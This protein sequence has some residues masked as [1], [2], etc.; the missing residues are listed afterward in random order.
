MLVQDDLQ[1]DLAG[2]DR[3]AVPSGFGRGRQLVDG[4]PGGFTKISIADEQA[5][6]LR[7]GVEL[8]FDIAELA[9]A[10]DEFVAREQVRDQHRPVGRFERVVVGV[11][12]DAGGLEFVQ[13]H[14]HGGRPALVV[15]VERVLGFDGQVELHLLGLGGGGGAGG[16]CERK[17]TQQYQLDSWPTFREGKPL[18]FPSTNLN[19]VHFALYQTRKSDVVAVLR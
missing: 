15:R 4:A 3:G 19:V 14:E 2:G 8:A 18:P 1:L 9:G 11:L 17:C 6:D 7:V 16:E 13:A 10:Q 5:E 12:E